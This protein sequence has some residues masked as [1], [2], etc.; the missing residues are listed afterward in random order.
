[1]F[2]AVRCWGMRMKW[3]ELVFR[4]CLVGVLGIRR[5]GA[6][7]TSDIGYEITFTIFA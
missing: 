3:V 7:G 1:M 6:F 5:R 4:V 2:A